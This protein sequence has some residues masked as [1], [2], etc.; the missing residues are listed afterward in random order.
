ME[1]SLVRLSSTA[2]PA[3]SFNL[4]P[5]GVRQA[6]QPNRSELWITQQHGTV[7]QVRLESLT[8]DYAASR[9]RPSRGRA[10]T[11]AFADLLGPCPVGTYLRDLL[12]TH[13]GAIE[14]FRVKIRFWLGQRIMDPRS[15]SAGS[16]EP[17]FP[18]MP[19]VSGHAWLGNLENLDDIADTQRTVLQQTENP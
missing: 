3:E 15:R 7:N 5:I 1:C 14:E 6:F 18:E 16:D 9:I 8:Y 19:Q 10:A 17:R 13:D 2:L 4:P 11:A 12:E